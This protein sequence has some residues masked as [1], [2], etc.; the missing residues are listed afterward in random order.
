[1]A[2][3]TQALQPRGTLLC[4]ALL[5]GPLI[6]GTPFLGLALGG[7]ARRRFALGLLFGLAAGVLLG[8]QLTRGLCLLFLL[9]LGPLG[10]ELLAAL[11]LLLGAE[12]LLGDAL[13]AGGLCAVDAAGEAADRRMGAVGA[14]DQHL[15]AT[16]LLEI[17]AVACLLGGDHR[18][19]QQVDQRTGRPRVARIL[20]TQ[21]QVVLQRVVARGRVQPAFLVGLGRRRAQFVGAERGHGIRRG[22]VLAGRCTLPAWRGPHRAVGGRRI[23]RARRQR[24]GH[25]HGDQAPVPLGVPLRCCQHLVFPPGSASRTF[26]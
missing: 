9:L 10:F 18:H 25:R 23:P 15:Q 13:F 1:M 8:S 3:R 24:A 20:V 7:L 11:R 4:R 16:R 2:P 17:V 19:R 21:R 14:L 22:G 26:A 6:G 5:G 12:R